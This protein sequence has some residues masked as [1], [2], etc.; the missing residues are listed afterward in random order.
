LLQTCRIWR[1]P[2]AKHCKFCDNCVLRFDHHCPWAGNCIGE[3][4][5]R[6]FFWFVVLTT[7][8][9]FA[10]M[11]LCFWRVYDAGDGSRGL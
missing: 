10:I 6:F 8:L 2:R 5:Y 7:I 1:P 9:A 4:N 11:V 3:R